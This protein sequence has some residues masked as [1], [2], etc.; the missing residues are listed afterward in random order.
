MG[1][2]ADYYAEQAIVD[3]YSDL[4][5]KGDDW[6]MSPLAK[7]QKGKRQKLKGLFFISG[8]SGSG[9]TLSA[10]LMAYGMMKEKY[11]ELSDEEIWDKIGVVD[12]E[13]KRSLI[14]VGM[15][16]DG[17]KT[18]IGEFWHQELIAPYST[19]NYALAVKQLKDAGVE[20]VIIDSLTHWWDG[21]GGILEEQAKV[22]AKSRSKNSYVAWGEMK[23]FIQEFV[24][25]IA[26]NDVHIIGTNRAKQDYAMEKDEMGKTSIT[27]V[28]L[29]PVQKDDLEYE[30]QIG[31]MI[32]MDHK[33]TATK[34]NTLGAVESLG[35][36][37]ITPDFGRMLLQWL[38]KGVDV[39]AQQEEER[40]A[41]AERRT[42]ILQTFENMAN[43]EPKWATYFTNQEIKQNMEFAEMTLDMLEQYYAVV[44]K[45][46]K[47]EAPKQEEAPKEEEQTPD[48]QQGLKDEILQLA[49]DEPQ[50]DALLREYL[51]K[52]KAELQDLDDKQ[53]KMLHEMLVRRKK[54]A[55]KG[56]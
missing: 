13:H 11:P 56:A 27:K 1:D 45:P 54:T 4:K 10:L 29:K 14:Y 51:D 24:K 15:M 52:N 53:V 43:A 12:T 26:Y 28:G 34:D 35:E 50:C 41:K 18:R 5:S 42:F 46:K 49:S 33:A 39:K 9:K 47:T 37:T 8:A 25:T 21:E 30:F 36:F 20:V 38:D 31:L 7:P 17:C 19:A 48:P 40:R 32:D 44:T 6:Q 55:Q 2:E 22:T 16:V 23:P 3:Y